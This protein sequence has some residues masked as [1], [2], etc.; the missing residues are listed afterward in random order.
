[1]SQKFVFITGGVVSGLGKGIT[2]ASLGRLLKARGYKV[3]LQKFDPYINIDPGRMSPYQHGEVFVTNDGAETDLD[4]GHYERFTDENMTI[5]S[6]IT[7]GQVYWNV[8]NKER[9][10]EYLGGTVQVIPHI[11]ND[12]KERVYQIGKNSGCDIVITE[13]GG[14]VGDIESQPFLEAARQIQIEVGRTNCIFVHVTLMPYI[15]GSN[16]LKSKPTQHSVKEL[17]SIGIQPDVLVCRS[18]FDIPE[19]MKI[20]LS[21]F[22]NVPSEAVVQNMTAP[23]IYAVPLLLEEQ[24]LG[25]SVC[26][27]LALNDCEPDLSDWKRII[28][29][30]NIVNKKVKIALVGKY[31]ELKDAYLS[32]IEA[33]RHGAMENSAEIE[34]DWIQSGDITDENAAELLGG[35]DGILVPGGF[36]ERGAEGKISAIKYARENKI[37]FLGIGLGM[38]LAVV[39]FARNVAGITSAD[40][41]EWEGS[42]TPVITIIPT[43]H[44]TDTQYEGVMRLGSY[45][46]KL[47]SGSLIKSVYNNELIYERHRH[48]NEVNNSYKQQLVSAGL[49]FTGISPD[50]KYCEAIEIADHPW[51]L[52]VQFHPEF[53]SR[54]TNAHPI[55]VE[56]IKASAR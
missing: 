18:E 1:M 35:V 30:E 40:C 9:R 52:G 24:G 53:K 4:I 39:E 28:E 25:S 51:F 10:G 49:K 48:R 23:S 26:K 42:T 6:D 33:L 14:T 11:T 55:F 46:C 7:A 34:T 5:D 12:I 31:V 54:P 21:M 2:A 8:L 43:N 36:G 27:S 22:C 19:D 45:A 37:P 20:K 50:E 16:E 3:T 41:S 32:I 38:Q 47:V 13:I 56:F 44:P 15:S 17:L 29:K